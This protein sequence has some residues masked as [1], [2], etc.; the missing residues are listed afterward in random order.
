M[1]GITEKEHKT[2]KDNFIR[3]FHITR[4]PPYI[5]LYMKRF[6]KNTFYVEKNPTIVNFPIKAVEFGG[7][8][9]TE[10]AKQRYG[11][12]GAQYDLISN[13]VHEGK[14]DSGAYKLQTLHQG[15]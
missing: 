10:E 3:K 7:D 5:I 12:T 9:L 6:T 4:L 15:S 11:E 8:L 14:P 13:I 1:G 2:Y